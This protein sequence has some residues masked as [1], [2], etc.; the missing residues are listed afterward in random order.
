MGIADDG[1]ADEDEDAGA[2]DRADAKRG[3]IPCRE[4][5][6]QTMIGMVC[7]REDLFNGLGSEES[8][9]HRTSLARMIHDGSSRNRRAALRDRRVEPRGLAPPS[10]A[11]PV[12]LLRR[13]QATKRRVPLPISM[14]RVRGA[15][16]LAEGSS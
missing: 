15:S 5:F 6:F 8:A 14:V 10:A 7:V 16:P 3:Q 2:D 12:P 13:G 11:A 9:D 1:G 4:S